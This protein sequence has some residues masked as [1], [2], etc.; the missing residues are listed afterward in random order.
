MQKTKMISLAAIA[1]ARILNATE[2]AVVKG[3]F[4]KIGDAIGQSADADQDSR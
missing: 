2:Q 1:K 4:R 3:G